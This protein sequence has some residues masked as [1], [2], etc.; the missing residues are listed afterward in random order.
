M[1]KDDI[2]GNF[3][4]LSQVEQ[5]IV[6]KYR[7]VNRLKCACLLKFFQKNGHF[8]ESHAEISDI[9]ARR[10][11]ALLEI[12]DDIDP[13]YD[14]LD[15]TGRRMR[16]DI[17]EISGFR[18]CKS[19]DYEDVQSYLIRAISAD[20]RLED[21]LAKCLRTW[22]FDRKIERPSPA[23]EERIL[24]SAQACLEDLRY[25][26]IAGK[27]NNHHKRSLDALLKSQP[28]ETYAPL[29]F[30][31][32]DPGKPCLNSVFVELSKLEIVNNL[33]LPQDL[34]SSERCKLRQSY[35]HR[36]AREPVRELRRRHDYTRYAL[37]AAFCLE[38]QEEVLDFFL[39][40]LEIPP[41][42]AQR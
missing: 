38:R 5:K 11:S 16:S 41:A 21:S 7:G 17:R 28:E 19:V 24:N 34:F 12:T 15:A 10:L 18:P 39:L 22:F 27:L 37:L 9:G 42:Q 13:N 26:T 2:G 36:A 33:A 8:P 3:W 1:D 25:Q 31:K 32:D 29:V 14:Y 35:R 40:L 6:N 4:S 23:R 20:F 30:L